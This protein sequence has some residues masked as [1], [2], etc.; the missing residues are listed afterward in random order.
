[1]RPII[2]TVG[3]NAAVPIGSNLA[4]MDDWAYPSVG[5]QCVVVGTVDYTV[6]TSMD[7]PNDPTNPVP[8]GSMMW[9]PSPDALA[10][11]ATASIMTTLNF[12]PRFIRILLNSGTG[13]V[14]ATILQSGVTNK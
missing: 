7:D 8:L 13:S 6:Q 4:R 11:A 14:T 9:S 2:V 10:V 12:V 3:P 1:M 5:I